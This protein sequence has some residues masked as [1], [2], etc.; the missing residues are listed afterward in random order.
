MRGPL[1]IGL[2]AAPLVI[3]AATAEAT[4]C[5]AGGPANQ[6][7]G[8]TTHFNWSAGCID[9]AE[10][11]DP[12]AIDHIFMNDGATD[13]LYRTDIN[14]TRSF[15][16]TFFVFFRDGFDEVISDEGPQRV[17]F[18]WLDRPNSWGRILSVR[19]SLF[20]AD[21]PRFEVLGRGEFTYDFSGIDC[22]NN[23]CSRIDLN[24]VMIPEPSTALLM[25]LGLAGLASSRR[26]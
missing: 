10:V 1:L 12:S 19:S 26:R 21:D 6:G 15:P 7:A 16:E 22:R 9:Q 18:T 5:N 8:G 2:L 24:L 20:G 14:H 3:A 4:L 11:A 25:G 13:F 17:L 23:A